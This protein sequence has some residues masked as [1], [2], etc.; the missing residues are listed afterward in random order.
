MLLPFSAQEHFID[1]E[2]SND[3]DGSDGES[4]E[5]LPD[6]V[7]P[8]KA[9]AESLLQAKGSDESLAPPVAQQLVQAIAKH[10][11]GKPMSR[12]MLKKVARLSARALKRLGKRHLLDEDERVLTHLVDIKA[13]SRSEGK[14][15][16]SSSRGGGGGGGGGGASSSKAGRGAASSGGGAAP[17]S[18]VGVAASSSLGGGA[19]TSRARPSSSGGGGASKKKKV[20][21]EASEGEEGALTTADEARISAIAASADAAQWQKTIPLL[22]LS[23]PELAYAESL[24]VDKQKEQQRVKRMALLRKQYG[25]APWQMLEEVVMPTLDNEADKALAREIITMKKKEEA[26]QK[27]KER[28]GVATRSA[29]GSEPG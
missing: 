28:V 6:L 17:S 4:E 18:K 7:S 26:D 22:R 23:P 15:P 16:S 11:K 21:E 19:S 20:E 14:S 27:K 10:P 24:L 12:Q 29:R 1:S 2:A 8:A 13:S 25:R 9:K 5:E 3:E